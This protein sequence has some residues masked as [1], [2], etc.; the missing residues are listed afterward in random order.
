VGKPFIL[1]GRGYVSLHKVGGLGVGF[2]TSD[3]GVLLMS[4]NIL[5]ETDPEKIGWQ[6]LPDGEIGLRTE[7]LRTGFSLDV[8]FQLE[9]LEPGQALGDDRNEAGHGV[10]LVTT[11]KGT[12]EIVL[13]DGRTENRWECVLGISCRQG[14]PGRHAV[15]HR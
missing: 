13:N 7:D 14:A 11:E 6:T 5:T 3:E 15:V 2:F 9:S 8:W 12:I 4:Q 1:D 10:A